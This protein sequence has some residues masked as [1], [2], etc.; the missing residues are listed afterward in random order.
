M[1]T[2][3]YHNLDDISKTLLFKM[4][5]LEILWDDNWS[6]RLICLAFRSIN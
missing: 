1:P 6:I 5:R 3:Y 4:I 2:P